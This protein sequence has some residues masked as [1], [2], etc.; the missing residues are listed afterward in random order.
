MHPLNFIF[1][2]MPIVSGN[3][4]T[5]S[6]YINFLF[7]RVTNFANDITISSVTLSQILQFIFSSLFFSVCI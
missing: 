7:P 4:I 2:F 1:K 5:I 6:Q 3:V